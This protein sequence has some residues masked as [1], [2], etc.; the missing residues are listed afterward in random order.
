MEYLNIEKKIKIFGKI[1]LSNNIF[2]IILKRNNSF[3][4]KFENFLT[5]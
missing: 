5:K 1:F 4:L 2:K 3:L